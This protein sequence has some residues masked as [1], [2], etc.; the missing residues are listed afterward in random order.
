MPTSAD[1]LYYY[2]SVKNGCFFFPWFLKCTTPTIL[3]DF[4]LQVFIVCL[5]CFLYPLCCL[6][7]IYQVISVTWL[8]VFEITASSRLILLRFIIWRPMSLLKNAIMSESTSPKTIASLE[9]TELSSFWIILFPTNQSKTSFN[10]SRQVSRALSHISCIIYEWGTEW[11]TKEK[12]FIAFRNNFYRR[13]RRID[14]I[15]THVFDRF[16]SQE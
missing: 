10:A 6:S 2:L 11:Y 15:I 12:S 16:S 7:L 9:N 4:M 8:I 14:S 13:R 3:L 1:F 5:L